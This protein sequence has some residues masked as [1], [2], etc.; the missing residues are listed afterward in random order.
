V[1]RHW[2]VSGCSGSRSATRISTRYLLL[3]IFCG[4]HLLAA[5][6]RPANIDGA[7]GS[8]EEVA[9]I[10][11][12][13]GTAHIRRRWPRAL[14]GPDG[15]Y[16]GRDRLAKSTTDVAAEERGLSGQ[17]DGAACILGAPNRCI[18]DSIVVMDAARDAI[19]DEGLAI[20]RAK[21]L[22]IA[23]EL[24]VARAKASEDTAL[25]AQQKLRIA[26]LER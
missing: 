23:A 15:L 24:A 26:K 9:R 8:I 3:Y 16:V 21:G 11:A 5:K 10:P 6:L 14:G 1:W 22:E 13:A 20:E 18:Y 17:K 2:R 19:P 4:R 25:I 7:A 12:F